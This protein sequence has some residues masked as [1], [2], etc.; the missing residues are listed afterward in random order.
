MDANWN[1]GQEMRQSCSSELSQ[2]EEH[3]RDIS[4]S[5][6]SNKNIYTV[7]QTNITTQQNNIN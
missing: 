4:H 1:T 5:N 7:T 6:H 2:H 3:R